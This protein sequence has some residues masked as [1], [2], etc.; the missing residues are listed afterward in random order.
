MTTQQPT[1]HCPDP[2]DARRLDPDVDPDNRWDRYWAEV[3]NETWQAARH[4]LDLSPRVAGF[5]ANH[6]QVVPVVRYDDDGDIRADLGDDLVLDWEAAAAQIAA[7]GFSSTEARLARLVA[8]LTTGAPFPLADLA[9]MNDWT[10][11][12]LAVLVRWA[13]DDRLDVTTAG[14][15]P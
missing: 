1:N 9:S 8:A 7:D 12:V 4:L 11:D 3:G 15:R 14:D 13:S 6:L 2:D 5:Y 10:T